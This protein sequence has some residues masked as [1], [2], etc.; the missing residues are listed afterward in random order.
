LFSSLVFTTGTFCLF[1]V[2]LTPCT[3]LFV[4]I[5]C[6]YAHCAYISKKHKS[7]SAASHPT[8]RHTVLG[9]LFFVD[10]LGYP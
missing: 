6:F 8:S 4:F 7:S 1:V 3:H 9:L 10:L 2:T 5:M